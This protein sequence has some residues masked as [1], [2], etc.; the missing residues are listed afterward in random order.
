MAKRPIWLLDEPTASLDRA[1]QAVLAT[2][3][4][5][6]L[7]DGGLVVAATHTPLGFARTRELPLGVSAPSA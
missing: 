6:H 3:V 5:A 1:S 4:N 2:V 7:A